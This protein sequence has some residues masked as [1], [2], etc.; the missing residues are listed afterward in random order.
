MLEPF[1][2]LY[3]LQGTAASFLLET[4]V[5]NRFSRFLSFSTLCS[6]KIQRRKFWDICALYSSDYWCFVSLSSN[7]LFKVTVL[8]EQYD[9]SFSLTSLNSTHQPT[10]FV[11]EKY[12]LSVVFFLGCVLASLARLSAHRLASF[13]ASLIPF[14]CSLH[15]SSLPDKHLYL[16][17]GMSSLEG[18]DN[19][20]SSFVCSIC[21]F[22]FLTIHLWQHGGWPIPSQHNKTHEQR[23]PHFC[24]WV[25]CGWQAINNKCMLFW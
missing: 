8:L 2:A 1:T 3:S 23:P 6:K 19:C 16:Y 24:L 21:T 17:L 5:S 11:Q 4:L 13:M 10:S 20:I 7:T 9:W 14:L 22:I 25:L 12:W 15:D 18:L